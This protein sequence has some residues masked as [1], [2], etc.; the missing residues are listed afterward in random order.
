MQRLQL[1]KTQEQWQSPITA[2][3]F[4]TFSSI[5]EVGVHWFY[6]VYDEL[7]GTSEVPKQIKIKL[8]E[9]S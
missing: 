8:T 1:R 7:A 9:I 3:G 6:I 2:Q 4:T 5:L